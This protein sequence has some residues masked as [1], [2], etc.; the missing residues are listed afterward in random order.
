MASLSRDA[1]SLARRALAAAKP[2]LVARSCASPASGPT[3]T[4]GGVAIAHSAPPPHLR[5][6]TRAARSAP[7]GAAPRVVPRIRG[8]DELE[9][10][11]GARAERLR[12]ARMRHEVRMFKERAKE[13]L[14]QEHWVRRKLARSAHE[15]RDVDSG[16]TLKRNDDDDS[17]LDGGYGSRRFR[18]SRT[19][20]ALSDAVAGSVA[21]ADQRCIRVGVL[22]VP[23]AGKSQLVNTLVGSHVS[24]VSPKTNTTRGETLGAVTRGETQVVFVDLPGIVGPEHY[25]NNKHAAKVTS[26][27]AAAAS[28]DALLFIVDAHR[29]ATRPD[30]RVEL[31]L[32]VAKEN[33]E[34]LRYTEA[35]GLAIPE[36]VLVLNK[37]DLF[38]AGDKDRVKG[39]ARA[40]ANL[41]PFAQLY[42]ISAKLGKGVKRVLD[43][44][45]AA[46]PFR[47]WALDP[48]KTTDKS[49]IDRAIEVVRECVYKRLHKE[50]P[51]NVVP[52]HDSWENFRNGSVKIEQTLVVDSV[53]VK[54]IVV[55]RRGSAIGQIGIR[56]RTILE[57]MFGK[58][59]HLVL[60]VKVRKKNKGGG[61]RRVP[62]ETDDRY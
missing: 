37:V 53:N 52:L 27:W 38:D 6:W 32:S 20:V 58:R 50:L 18:L 61:A 5:A 43:H 7:Y 62:G 9:E 11:R 15:T 19:A 10:S 30:P 17:P 59:V 45:A 28:C 16:S 42:P 24:A 49:A 8:D 21:E 13:E 23:N 34:R 56:A 14:S 57:E 31:L 26:A 41:H 22:G 25:R 29:Q 39:V 60:H 47:P 12:R 44:F 54:Q 4:L 3:P 40:L 33:L 55:G 46:A 2:W 48:S 36:S 51:Y 35:S 1:A